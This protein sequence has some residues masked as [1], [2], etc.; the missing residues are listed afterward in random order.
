M[1]GYLLS[2]LDW[3]QCDSLG[4]D[5]RQDLIADHCGDDLALGVSQK[6]RCDWLDLQRWVSSP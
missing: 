2:W 5:D 3:R 1:C 4:V 6:L